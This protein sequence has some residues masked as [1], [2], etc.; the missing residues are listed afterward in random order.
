MVGL[1][2][3]SHQLHHPKA[4]AKNLP[5]QSPPNPNGAQAVKRSVPALEPRPIS[6]LAMLERV[7]HLFRSYLREA[8][9][10]LFQLGKARQKK[11]EA[12]ARS[13]TGEWTQMMMML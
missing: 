8:A 12:L 6:I 7:V 11:R 10:M 13:M 1:L 9:G 4:R 2:S 3:L 5:L